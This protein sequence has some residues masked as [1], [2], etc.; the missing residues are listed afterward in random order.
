MLE[1]LAKDIKLKWI[2]MHLTKTHIWATARCIKTRPFVI[3]HQL[4]TENVFW[5]CK[6]CMDAA[7]SCFFDKNSIVE[8][9]DHALSL[10]VDATWTQ[11]QHSKSF[12][13]EMN[14]NSHVI[15]MKPVYILLSSA[16][17]VRWR[18][19]RS[20]F[21]ATAFCSGRPQACL[22]QGRGKYRTWRS[23]QRGT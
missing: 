18:I 19:H 13:T 23:L 21:K 17:S 7:V 1:R 8:L 22:P 5:L 10:T 9:T 11:M 12:Y 2:W 15:T 4:E 6:S 14:D 16:S 20:S 3:F